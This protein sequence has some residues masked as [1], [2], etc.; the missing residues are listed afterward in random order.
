MRFYERCDRYRT[1][2]LFVT[3]DGQRL[4]YQEGYH[5]ADEMLQEIPAR[6]LVF[7]F[8]QNRPELI[9][10]YLGMLEKGAVPVLLDAK[11]GK[12]QLGRLFAIYQPGY[13]IFPKEMEEILPAGECLWSNERY[14][15]RRTEYSEAELYPE[16]ALLLSTSGSTGSPKLVRLSYKNLESNA[17]SI[18][19]YLEITKED[20]PVTTLPMQYTYGLSVINSHVGCGAA[21]LLT[22]QTVF[23]AGFWDFVK[24]E[25]AT[26]MAGVPRTYE[27]LRRLRIHQMELPDLTVF[28]QAGGRLPQQL[29][30]YMARWCL[31]KK[32]RFYIMY[33][34]TEATARMSYLPWEWC[35]KKPG[36][37]GIPIPGGTFALE[38]ENGAVIEEPLTE[39]ELVYYGP[40]VSLGY[41]KERKDLLS[42]DARR[43]R[44]KTGDLA[45]RDVDGCYYI[46]GRK[47]RFLK[48]YGNRVSLDMLEKL[49]TEQFPEIDFACTGTDDCVQVFA[50]FPLHTG[51]RPDTEQIRTFLSRETRLHR[52][53]FQVRILE[54]IPRNAAGKIQYQ[55]LT[56]REQ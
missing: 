55:L 43:G 22:D 14:G 39:G 2:T 30:Q 51:E 25:K 17:A 26:S 31:E 9:V 45:K 44:L 8:C 21:I 49:L 3:D 54:K 1:R 10:S 53:A 29:Q 6:S 16:L 41:A 38:N 28:T 34:Q 42:G 20:R 11:M 23:D 48:V 52:L 12:Q 47:N 18:S 32:I 35:E 33:G 19:L 15:V 24:K 27:M 36:S 4:T 40:N 13:V 50:E 5:L 7:L 46:T 56:V 37:I